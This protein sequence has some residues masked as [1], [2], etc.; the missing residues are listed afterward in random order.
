MRL[1]ISSLAV[2]ALAGSVQAQDLTYNHPTRGG[3]A[4]IENSDGKAFWVMLGE[5]AGV[6]GALSNERY[7]ENDQAGADAFEADG[8]RQANAALAQ[9]MQDRGISRGDAAALVRPA[10]ERG[11]AFGEAQLAAAPG[12][13]Q[14]RAV[15]SSA[16]RDVDDA[17]A[18][19]RTSN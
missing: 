9:L 12:R 17:Y 7:Y 13:P 5:C 15:L 14:V 10:V 18:R 2:L 6:F 4:L 16:C 19:V 11:R 1:L 3:S 8:T